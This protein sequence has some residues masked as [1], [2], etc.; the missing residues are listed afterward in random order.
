[1]LEV[2]IAGRDGYR[3]AHNLPEFRS[4]VT[5]ILKVAPLAP[6]APQDAAPAAV[7]FWARPEGVAVI[8]A[9]WAVIHAFIGSFFEIAVNADDAVESY[10]VQSLELSYVP[11]NPPL[12][13]WLLYGLQRVLG[14]GP[15]SFAVLRYVLLFACAMLVW[16]IARR[17]IADPRLQALATF[18]LSAI[19]V[20]GYHSHRILTHSNVMIVAIAGAVLTILA[21]ARQPSTRLYAGLGL[22]IA[23]GLLGKFGF[24]GFLGVF[25][26]AM[27]LEPQFRRVLLDRRIGI[28]ILVAAF[29]LAIYGGALYILKQDVAAAVA[30]TI[31]ATNA[32]FDDVL[33]SFL[34]ALAGYTLPLAA[35]MAAV[36]LPF[37]RG[38][39]ALPSSPDRAAARRL[40]R[41]FIIMGVVVTLI[42]VLVAQTS[43]LRDRYFH[44]FLLL[45]PVYLFAELERLGGW[46]PRVT[47]Y[48]ALL[49][50]IAVG[51]VGGRIAVPLWPDPRLCGRCMAAEPLYK[52]RVAVAGRLGSAPTLVADDR[53]S[54]GRLRAAIPGARVVIAR[55]LQY[56]PPSRP[57]TGCARVTGIANGLPFL[58][59]PPPGKDTAEPSVKWWSPLMNPHRVSDWQ[60]TKL[61]LEDP[62]CR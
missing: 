59:L 31:G 22:W 29:P 38:E 8:I 21:L 54:A 48:L 26:V 34:G 53:I 35:L 7:P 27:L 20:I 41:N 43:S 56:R 23:A 47:L 25:V 55:E 61:P 44:V 46:R 19:W 36:F 13:D 60:I 18:S 2:A 40:L 4:P 51:V 5:E 32:G 57:A 58:L 45:L 9:A 52:L 16:R 11:R 24:L 10:M 42:G 15:L 14:T 62:L 6:A 28:T 1:M 49:A 17:V 12:Y 30:Q 50:L 37:N 39:G 3:G 33:G